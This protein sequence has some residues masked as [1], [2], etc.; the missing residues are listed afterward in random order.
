M[1]SYNQVPYAVLIYGDAF[2]NLLLTV[3]QHTYF[4]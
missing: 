4:F 2:Q 1:L 3:M